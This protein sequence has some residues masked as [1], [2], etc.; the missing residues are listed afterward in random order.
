M[1]DTAI[2]P[3]ACC[4]SSPDCLRDGCRLVA[5]DRQHDDTRAVARRVVTQNSY[6][7]DSIYTPT[8][9]VTAIEPSYGPDL[10]PLVRLS[11]DEIRVEPY[12][13]THL[14]VALYSRGGAAYW[15]KLPLL[16]LPSDVLGI[17]DLKHFGVYHL[18]VAAVKKLRVPA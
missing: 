3:R 1:N 10:L 2:T 16:D 6:A 12:S 4:C 13:D 17:R 18:Y 15:Q 5:L 7:G 9:Q 11:R 8:S 14:C